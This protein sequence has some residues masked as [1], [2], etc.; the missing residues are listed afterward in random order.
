MPSASPSTLKR[1]LS[2]HLPLLG[3]LL[4]ACSMWAD[5]SLLPPA[6]EPMQPPGHEVIQ[7]GIKTVVAEAKLAGPIE[8]SGVRK[9]DHGLGD[10]FVCLRQANPSP[11]KQHVTYSVFFDS[12]YK[13]SRQ[14]VILEDCEQQPYSRVN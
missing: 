9:T 8:I 11:E 12:T 3:L 10:Y 13:G 5:T 7:N 1:L 14:S 6:V 4:S 2:A